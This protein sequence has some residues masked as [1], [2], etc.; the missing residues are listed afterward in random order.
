M[1]CLPNLCT[2]MS[3][4]SN[5]KGKSPENGCKALHFLYAV[6]LS[7]S[8]GGEVFKPSDAGGCLRKNEKGVQRAQG[9]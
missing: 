3:R 1:Y 5:F 9:K 2:E 4:R 8:P 7:L 6:H